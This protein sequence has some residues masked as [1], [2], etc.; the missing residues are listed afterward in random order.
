MAL[1]SSTN[2]VVM[3]CKD[4]SLPDSNLSLERPSLLYVRGGERKG[5]REGERERGR[6]KEERK[7]GRKEKRER[8]RKG[9]LLNK[10]ERERKGRTREEEEE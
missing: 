8:E 1:T 4:T 2:H 10:W 3:F 5:R 7:R 9:S 6:G